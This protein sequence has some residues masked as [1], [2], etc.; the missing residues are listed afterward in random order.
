LKADGL[1]WESSFRVEGTDSKEFA[2]DVVYV[3]HSDKWLL[4]DL[5]SLSVMRWSAKTFTHDY[6]RLRDA[7]S[8]SV[9]SVSFSVNP[10]RDKIFEPIIDGVALRAV[11]AEDRIGTLRALL[12]SLCD[13]VTKDIR[14]HRGE[15]GVEAIW[16]SAG[17]AA[18]GTVENGIASR[19]ASESFAAF[20]P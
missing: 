17:R 18:E 10:N 1:S 8:R 15:V 19:R 4:F 16:S 14:L 13:H 12:Q 3:R 2:A 9:S 5:L 6:E 7:F 11:A 20:V